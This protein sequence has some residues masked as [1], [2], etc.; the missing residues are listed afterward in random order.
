MSDLRPPEQPR[1]SPTEERLQSYSSDRVA[2]VAI[3]MLAVLMWTQNW[4]PLWLQVIL[5]VVGFV[6]TV[7]AMFEAARDLFA[8]LKVWEKEREL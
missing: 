1:T 7:S 4:G 3:V 5:G 2:A 6:T 8:K